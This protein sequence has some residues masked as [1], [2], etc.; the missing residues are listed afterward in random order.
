MKTYTT[1]KDYDWQKSGYENVQGF[2]TN[3]KER[4]GMRKHINHILFLIK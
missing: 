4:A 1:A 2:F 3:T